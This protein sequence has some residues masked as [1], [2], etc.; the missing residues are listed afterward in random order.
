MSK[1]ARR[2]QWLK[3]A[4][5][6]PLTEDTE[7]LICVYSY[8]NETPYRIATDLNRSEH[9]VRKILKE[10]KESGRYDEHI[11]RHLE[12]LANDIPLNRNKTEYL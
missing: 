12:H 3:Q 4:S 7:F 11:S 10:A 6:R 1:I 2:L 8:R 5:A 9:Q